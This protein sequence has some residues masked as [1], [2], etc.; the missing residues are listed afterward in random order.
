[1]ENYTVEK[2]GYKWY[3]FE[4]C[5]NCGINGVWYC[6][7]CNLKIDNIDSGKAVFKTISTDQNTV[8]MVDKDCLYKYFLQQPQPTTLSILPMAFLFAIAVKKFF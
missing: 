8:H 7:F 4:N 1:V 2:I 5:D 6:S 3:V